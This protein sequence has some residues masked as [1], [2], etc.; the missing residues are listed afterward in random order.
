MKVFTEC[1]AA[2]GHKCGDDMTAECQKSEDMDG[3]TTKGQKQDGV[4][5]E[6]DIHRDGVTREDHKCCSVPSHR[7]C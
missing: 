5:K 3:V 1:G 4:T 2:L 6:S 7:N